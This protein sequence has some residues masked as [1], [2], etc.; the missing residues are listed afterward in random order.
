M[1]T[2][3]KFG[4]FDEGDNCFVL[5][6]TPPR[7]WINQH[8]NKIGEHEMWVEAT[9][10]G[11][12]LSSVRDNDGNTC[13]IS[14]YDSKYTFI[15][16]DETNKTFSPWGEPAPTDVE[17]R[18]CRY[19]PE[20]TLITGS[21]DGIKVRQRTFVPEDL[22]GEV[23]T[24]FVKNNSDRERSVSVFGYMKFDLSGRDKEGNGVYKDNYATVEKD[25]GGVFCVN[26]NT[27][28]PT[29]RFKAYIITT[30]DFHSGTAYRDNLT[31]SDFSHST[32][33]IMWGGDLDGKPGFGPDCAGAVQVKLKLAPG[34]EQRV[35]Y[36]AGQAVS[37]DEVKA[38][39]KRMTADVIDRSLAKQKE[40]E[41]VRREAFTVDTGNANYNAL[42]NTFVKKQMYCYLIN[43]S[44]F[45]DNL[46]CDWAYAL[47]NYQDAR[48][49]LLRALSSQMPDGSVI[50]GFRP[51][52]RLKYSD[53]PSWINMVVPALIKESGDF[54]LLDEKVP[55]F[56]SSEKGTVF[57]HML[58]SM[59]YLSDDTGPSGL[60]KQHHADWNDGLEATKESGE[61]ESVMVTQQLCCGLMEM[62][63]LAGRIGKDDIKREAIDL[64]ETFKKRINEKA[65]DGEWYVRT[66]CADGYAIGSSQN[67]E[68]FIFLNPQVWAVFSGI[69]SPEQQKKAFGN[70]EKYLEEKVGYRIC[71]PGFSQYDPRV[72]RM[73]NS[74]PGHVENGGCYNHAA[75]FKTVAD[76]MMGR[77]EKAWRT[78][79]K[80]TPDNPENPVSNSRVEPF[81]YTN[82]YTTVDL[83]YGQAGYPWRTGTAVWFTMALIE[84]ILGARRG[85]D[86][87]IIDP[88]VPESM[89]AVSLQ[90]KFRGATYNI[91][92]DNTSGG[93]KGVKEL[94]VDGSP[95][96]G[97]V[98]PLAE[99]GEFSVK[100]KL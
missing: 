63:D 83:V 54:S 51:L 50:H 11:D 79:V 24:L 29:D 73:S 80:V 52:N 28:V 62:A 61:R 96:K 35:D 33:R 91:S 22:T 23:W 34:E 20:K 47:V 90:R 1:S 30:G 86:G 77:A 65:W 26:R 25:I 88:C 94:L 75:G 58:R 99:S 18:E 87:L 40:N 72:G 71:Y 19:Y 46:Q 36:I 4:K 89:P 85:Y 55:Y 41:D 5:K 56:E 76:C 38:V 32:P 9:N 53:K 48:N 8:Y 7:K 42:M 67:K 3:E 21:C 31:R 10:I 70:V 57:D 49:N 78:F 100:V 2:V 13:V 17:E 6:N 14:S 81:S 95:V 82:F 74:M 37:I 39:R 93:C 69:A 44:G 64:Y 84:W 59:R 45:R 92:I 98:L 15:R 60:C 16:D 97:P 27:E 12:G 68:G 43:K 66:I